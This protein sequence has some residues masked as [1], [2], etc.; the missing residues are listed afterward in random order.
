M[1]VRIRGE[2]E[3]SVFGLDENRPVVVNGWVNLGGGGDPAG[4]GYLPSAMAAPP[5][6]LPV[7][8]PSTVVCSL[9]MVPKA[10]PASLP[11]SPKRP[12]TIGL[13]RND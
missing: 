7:T 2:L 3:G 1:V 4:K 9:R 6:P 11:R 8:P 5:P 12:R 13:R 10:P